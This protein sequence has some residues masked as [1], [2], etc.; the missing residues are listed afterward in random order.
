MKVY[1]A[2]K[3]TGD[4]NYRE[5]FAEAA[6]AS[7]KR[8]DGMSGRTTERILNAAAKG[9][10]FLFL[11]VMLDL[12]WIGA[13]CVFEGIVHESRVDGVVLAWLCLLLVREIEQF[14]RKIRGDGR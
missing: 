14:E 9:L 8:G 5:K 10:L 2:G 7:G 4:P 3:I 11:Y 13:E 6:N 1:L 12:C